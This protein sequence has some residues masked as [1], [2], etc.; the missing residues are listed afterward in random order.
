[1]ELGRHNGLKIRRLEKVVPV[2]F[3]LRAPAVEC[4]R[5][6]DVRCSSFK[7][8]V[9]VRSGLVVLQRRFLHVKLT[10]NFWERGY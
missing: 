1:M 6:I 9:A 2:R 8:S 4:D 3:R 5:L 10:S 7:K